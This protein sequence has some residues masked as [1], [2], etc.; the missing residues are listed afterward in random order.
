M[1]VSGQCLL[2]TGNPILL[3][4]WMLITFGGGWAYFFW[5][6][7]VYVEKPLWLQ[8]V[9]NFEVSHEPLQIMAA[10][11]GKINAEAARFRPEAS[12]L[13]AKEDQKSV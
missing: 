8:D 4:L 7:T 13:G 11:E 3:L 12:T 2:P 9:G 1:P 10:F 5:L 6:P